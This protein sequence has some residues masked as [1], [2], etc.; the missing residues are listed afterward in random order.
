MPR[1]VT[2][3]SRTIII[4]F[5]RVNIIYRTAVERRKISSFSPF[6]FF[7]LPSAAA[8]VVISLLPPTRLKYARNVYIVSPV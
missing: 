2:G 4:I 3:A 5:E 6:C 7:L 1:G 8:V